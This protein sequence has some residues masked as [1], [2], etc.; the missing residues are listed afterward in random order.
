MTAMPMLAP[1]TMVCP[2]IS[3]AD[4][5]GYEFVDERERSVARFAWLPQK[6]GAEILESVFP[7]I[8]IA[9]AAYRQ[10][11]FWS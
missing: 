9:L 10:S 4:Y 7:F 5:N 8:G 2:L 11:H 1:M 6:P 3:P